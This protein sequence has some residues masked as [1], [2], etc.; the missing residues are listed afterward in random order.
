CG[1][2]ASFLGRGRGEGMRSR[3]RAGGSTAG[4]EAVRRGEADLAGIHLLDPAT[5]EYN[6]PFLG[7]EQMLVRGYR[8][9]QGIVFRP[10]D[11]R[12]AQIRAGSVSDG[13]ACQTIAH[14]SGSHGKAE[15]HS[16]FLAAALADPDCI[17]INRNRGSGTRIL[18][19]QLL[20]GAQPP[21]YS[22][23]AHSHNAV[24]AAVA[25]GRADWGVAIA[26]VARQAALGFVPL[27][28][29]HYDFV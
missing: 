10:D 29:E 4:L 23:E 18:I 5:N 20:K 15:I 6:R 2:R 11:R 12:F 8:R 28:E 21:G 16:A 19:D 13:R 24:A 9:L 27:R 25:Q 14:A 7:P 1:G 3:F 22:T 26:P 17:L